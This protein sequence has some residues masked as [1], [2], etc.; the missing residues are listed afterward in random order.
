[1]NQPP[2]GTKS[3][4]TQPPP[5]I[6]QLPTFEKLPQQY[7]EYKAEQVYQ[8]LTRKIL[9]QIEKIEKDLEIEQI[10]QDEAMARIVYVS[11]EAYSDKPSTIE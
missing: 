10:S 7:A 4:L 1:M 3:L 8:E 5:G 11:P 9:P 2:P 6:K